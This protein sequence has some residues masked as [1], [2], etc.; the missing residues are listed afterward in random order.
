[1]AVLVGGTTYIRGTGPKQRDVFI[2]K[3]LV[4]EYPA[5]SMYSGT[6]AS[7]VEARSTTASPIEAHLV[8]SLDLVRSPSLYVA[9]CIRTARMSWILKLG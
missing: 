5:A 4:M 6:G 3:V 8:E 1:M 9:G 7:E 2:R